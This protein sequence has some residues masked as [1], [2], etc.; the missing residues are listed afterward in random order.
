ME[1]T[2]S[3]PAKV[4]PA[5]LAILRIIPLPNDTALL[6]PLKGDIHMKRI[7]I[8]GSAL[9][10]LML[11]LNTAAPFSASA[12]FIP[13]LDLDLALPTI[14]IPPAATATP[15]LFTLLPIPIPPF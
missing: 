2:I 11:L 9:L 4:S 3:G 14:W 5:A 13:D 1:P 15:K 7:R 10:L 6:S 8:I 12:V